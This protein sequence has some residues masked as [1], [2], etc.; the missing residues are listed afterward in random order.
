MSYSSIILVEMCWGIIL[1]GEPFWKENKF[2]IVNRR[3]LIICNYNG[4]RSAA[5]HLGS[6]GQMSS[7]TPDNYMFITGR[8]DLEAQYLCNYFW[9]Q[10]KMYTFNCNLIWISKV[11]NSL[12][13]WLYEL[14]AFLGRWGMWTVVWVLLSY[15][16]GILIVLSGICPWN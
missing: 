4:Q 16:P 10:A 6:G 8:Q 14:Y 11:K 12:H 5:Y 2:K 15:L 1:E 3:Q 7:K 9:V 13:S